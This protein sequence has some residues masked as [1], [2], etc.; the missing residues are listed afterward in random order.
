MQGQTE[1]GRTAWRRGKRVRR[2]G[3]GREE[4]AESSGDGE[5]QNRP[6]KNR[7]RQ[8][9]PELRNARRIGS[10]INLIHIIGRIEQILHSEIVSILGGWGCQTNQTVSRIREPAGAG[11]IQAGW[12]GVRTARK[13]SGESGG[14][15]HQFNPAVSVI[16]PGV[17][18]CRRIKNVRRERV[19]QI[20]TNRESLAKYRRPPKRP[21]LFCVWNARGRLP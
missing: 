12:S 14:G 3:G 15:R 17:Q 5:R 19:R 4:K 20:L 7:E 2:C 18:D 13:T 16:G 8:G 1:R 10:P 21:A 9:Q 6:E 11:P